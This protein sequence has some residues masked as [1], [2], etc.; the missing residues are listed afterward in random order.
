MKP[1]VFA[2]ALA[3]ATFLAFL[4]AE[5]ARFSLWT[6]SDEPTHLA[7]AREWRYGPGMVSNFEHPV[8]MKILAGAFLPRE[9]P[10]ME[11]DETRAGRAPMPFVF[12]GLA[13][14]TGLL[15]RALA[16][17]AAGLAA[18]ALVAVEPTL[19]GHGA[20]VQSD[21]LVTFFLVAAALALEHA[22][23]SGNRK[24]LV[25]CGVLYG[26]AMSAKY[27]A[28]PFF[29][30]FALIAALRFAAGSPERFGRRAFLHL[31]R[32]SLRALPKI[33]L[34]VGFPALL[35]LFL[36]QFLT[37]AGTSGAAF[38]AGIAHEFAGLPQERA[39]VALARTF[40]KAI[41]AYGAGLLFVQGVAGPGERFNYFFGE[42]SGR[43][44]GL[45]FPV[46]LGIKLTT[47]T[48]LL[49]LAALVAAG[50]LLARGARLRRLLAARA[51]WPAALGG[52]YLLAAC[53]S[54]VNIGVRHA[55]PVVPFAIAAAAGALRTLVRRRRTVAVAFAAVVLA[56]GAESIARMGHEIS[57]GNLFC[58]GPAGV[59]AILSDSN[60]DWGQE[61]GRLF[62]RARRGD[63]GRVGI[64]SLIVD[65]SGARSV[66]ILGQVTGPDAAV[67]TVFFSRFLWDLASAIGKNGEPWPKFV[68]LRGW[69][70]PLRRGLE[71]RAISMEPFG[72][73]QLLMRLRPGTPST[74]SPSA[75]PATTR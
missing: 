47:A 33:L 28:F 7:A 1:G 41:A 49:V 55:L 54:N 32:D 31:L 11:I 61:Q 42:I 25:A 71:A 22:A 9:R 63:L 37:F 29:A 36:I 18:A 68:W 75:P 44:Y 15:A 4:G 27:S 40:P 48:V 34:F 23:R 74:A 21:V 16:G 24:T 57:F 35:A 30:V 66:G 52:A 13:L 45:Y 65:E 70:P 58:G 6:T 64:V 53:A 60:V 8:L 51:C 19:R 3:A 14:V 56:A 43:G 38:Q 20:L 5:R 2:G 26:F 73:T 10:A 59:P 50:V 39:A 17:D 62:E 67:D 72:D 69:L 46:A 12:A